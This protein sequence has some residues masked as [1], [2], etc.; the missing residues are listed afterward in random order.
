M[1]MG[2]VWFLLIGLAAGWLAGRIMKGKGFG[3][4]GDLI[5]GVVG[6]ILGGWLFSDVLKVNMGAGIIPSLVV[7][8]IGAIILIWI[9]RLIKKA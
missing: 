6:A 3:L 5:V 8:L 2:L 4:I 1:G 9:I 7:A